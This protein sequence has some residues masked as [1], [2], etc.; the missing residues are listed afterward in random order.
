MVFSGPL[1]ACPDSSQC[2]KHVQIQV[3]KFPDFQ[4]LLGFEFSPVFYE[5]KGSLEKMASMV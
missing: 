1:E 2:N 4:A 3:I 5:E